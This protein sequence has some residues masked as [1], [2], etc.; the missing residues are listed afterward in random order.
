MYSNAIFF[1]QQV[2][3]FNELSSQPLGAI[4]ILG[5]SKN[6]G[7]LCPTNITLAKGLGGWGQKMPFC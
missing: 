4:P 3:L 6:E 5:N 1:G 7:N 2:S